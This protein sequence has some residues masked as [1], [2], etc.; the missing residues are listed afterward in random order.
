MAQRAYADTVF[1]LQCEDELIP[2]DAEGIYLD[3]TRRLLYVSLTR[4]AAPHLDR[5]QSTNGST[6]FRRPTGG[7]QK[8]LSRFIADYRL[9][10]TTIEQ[11]LAYA[12]SD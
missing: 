2:G 10:A 6:T 11:Y 7:H 12:R 3:E 9:E 8:N 5:M 1:V 4:A